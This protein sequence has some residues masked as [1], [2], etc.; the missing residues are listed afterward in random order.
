MSRKSE[1][2]LRGKNDYVKEKYNLFEESG[3]EYE[4]DKIVD[5]RTKY[6]EN[7]YLIKWAG[8]DDMT[9][10]PEHHLHC[11]QK[12]E[13]FLNKLGC[14][15]NPK[16]KEN[17]SFTTNNN[18]PSAKKQKL[19]DRRSIDELW[20]DL[21]KFE[22]MRSRSK[23]LPNANRPNNNLRRVSKGSIESPPPTDSSSDMDIENE[24]PPISQYRTNYSSPSNNYTLTRD[25]DNYYTTFLN[26]NGQQS[27]EGINTYPN[28]SRS[29]NIPKDGSHP[30][31]VPQ[32]NSHSPIVT[33]NSSQ[34]INASL[35]SLQTLCFP[36]NNFQ[37]TNSF[38]NNLQTTATFLNSS[39][40]TNTFLNNS[41]VLDAPQNNLQATDPF[42]NNSQ[43]TVS[44]LNS[45]QATNTFSNSSQSLNVP[46]NNPHS[47]QLNKSPNNL[48]ITEQ[49]ESNELSLINPT[50]QGKWTG[51]FYKMVRSQK[52]PIY[53]SRVHIDPWPRMTPDLEL[54]DALK[55]LDKIVLQNLHPLNYVFNV[56]NLI[57]GYGPTFVSMVFVSGD[58]EAIEREKMMHKWSERNEAITINS[59]FINDKDF[60][61]YKTYTGAEMNRAI[62]LPE[63][64]YKNFSESNYCLLSPPDQSESFDMECYMNY[65]G[66]NMSN[67]EDINLDLILVKICPQE[68]LIPGGIIMP[69]LKALTEFGSLAYGLKEYVNRHNNWVIKI[70]PYILQMMLNTFSL[71]TKTDKSSAQRLFNNYKGIL[72]GLNEGYIK[73]L[74]PVELYN[75]ND[76]RKG[77]LLLFNGQNAISLLQTISTFH[78]NR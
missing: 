1:Q 19:A 38:L 65:I 10:E 57:N 7:Y 6:G 75:I 2:D 68:I 18:E 13:I 60:K 20:D 70:H 48:E 3:E 37:A 42:L 72:D 50:F 55:S 53:I 73:Y 33:N 16:S 40:V 24:I 43:A 9:W 22:A 62:K 32:N 41:H 31:D 51:G 59:N 45:S 54:F 64:L 47:H 67:L 78:Y 35:N 4:V 58:H 52:I 30:L 5:M 39:Q 28:Q 61:D 71:L 36:Q 66:A 44:F 56:F 69:T 11:Q 23:S 27:M 76:Q 74:L 14:G 63:N 17:T 15:Y 21:K 49:K 12:L 29:A 26:N 25:K 34:V 77:K 8:Y 46:Q